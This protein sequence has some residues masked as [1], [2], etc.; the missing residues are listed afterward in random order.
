MNTEITVLGWSVILLAVTIIAQ[1][2]STTSELGASYGASARDDALQASNPY[3][4]RCRRALNNYLETYTAFVALALALTVTGK[5]GGLGALGAQI[6]FWARVVYLPLYVY[7][8][9]WLRSVAWF[10]SIAGL[11]TMLAR[12]LA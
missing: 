2:V 9:P 10:V 5:A 11:V 6:W 4:G 8:V 12:L 3:A 1:S 7:G